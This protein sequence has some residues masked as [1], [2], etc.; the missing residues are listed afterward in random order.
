M[1]E[2][3]INI[4]I[5]LL[6]LGFLCFAVILELGK[7]EPSGPSQ[8]MVDYWAEIKVKT[9][10]LAK[11]CQELGGTFYE[12]NWDCGSEDSRSFYYSENYEFIETSESK[13]CSEFRNYKRIDLPVKCEKYS[14]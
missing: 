7:L 10:K 6:F 14:Y 13:Q 1:K 11:S 2:T 3:S 8:E 5:L 4:F 12:E 9:D